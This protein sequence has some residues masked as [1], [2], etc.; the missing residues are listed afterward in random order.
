MDNTGTMIL[1]VVGGTWIVLMLGAY[2]IYR[3]TETENAA[4]PYIVDENGQDG[5]EE[6]INNTVPG[7][8]IATVSFD[9]VYTPEC[10]SSG[11]SSKEKVDKFSEDPPL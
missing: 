7:L 5:N 4:Q 9:D 10:G 6:T 8:S 2:I 3:W 11:N 1:V